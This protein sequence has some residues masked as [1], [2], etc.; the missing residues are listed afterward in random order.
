MWQKLVDALFRE[1]HTTAL[2]IIIPTKLFM[3]LETYIYIRNETSEADEEPLDRDYVV[4]T[5][6]ARFL[7][8]QMTKDNPQPPVPALPPMPDTEYT[9]GRR[10][11]RSAPPVTHYRDPPYQ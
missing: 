4:G 9:Q 7:A 2:T 1:R 11:A 10:Q 5:V 3:A 8:R 6:L